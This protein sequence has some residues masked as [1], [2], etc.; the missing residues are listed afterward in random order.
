MHKCPPGYEAAKTAISNALRRD[1]IKGKLIPKFDY[2]INGNI[3]GPIEDS[4]DLAESRVEVES[5]RLWL[6]KRGIRTG[7]Y[8]PMTTDAPDYLDPQNPRYAPKLAAAVRAPRRNR[9]ISGLCRA[10][11]IVEAAMKSGALITA[12]LAGCHIF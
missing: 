12:R 11:I 10:T 4:I 1:A 8:F 7:F 9:I 3:C 2:D 5:L 6:T